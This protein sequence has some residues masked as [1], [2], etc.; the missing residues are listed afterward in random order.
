MGFWSAAAAAGRY[1]KHAFENLPY[2]KIAW[3]WSVHKACLRN[4]KCLRRYGGLSSVEQNKRRPRQSCILQCSEHR[5]QLRQRERFSVFHL[6]NDSAVRSLDPLKIRDFW[7]HCFLRRLSVKSF[8][9][10][11][12]AFRLDV[13]LP[14]KLIPW[15]P[16][17]P[18]DRFTRPPYKLHSKRRNGGA[19][20]TA[21]AN[22]AEYK[23]P[24]N[25]TDVN[26]NCGRHHWDDQHARRSAEEQGGE[27]PCSNPRSG[28]QE[29]CILRVRIVAIVNAG[30]AA[31]CVR[32]S[33]TAAAVAEAGYAVFAQVASAVDQF[34]EV[35]F[36]HRVGHRLVR[37]VRQPLGW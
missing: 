1:D 7:D 18:P 3:L 4:T 20:N 30:S 19:S 37:I 29:E 33:K 22:D 15:R 11:D 27:H 12:T 24:S 10:N 34:G 36:I 35:V 26:E 16:H 21:A 28:L 13:N 17:Q 23:R 31:G 6:C 5:S 14:F 9:G 25:Q 2:W 8:I 32:A